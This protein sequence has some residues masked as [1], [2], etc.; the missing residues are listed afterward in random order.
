MD[1]KNNLKLPEYEFHYNRDERLSMLPESVIKMKNPEQGN[2]Q[3]QP[4]N[5]NTSS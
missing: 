4:F 1:D 3:K 2:F 5:G